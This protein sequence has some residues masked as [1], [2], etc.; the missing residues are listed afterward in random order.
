[1]QAV[2]TNTLNE[3]TNVKDELNSLFEKLNTADNMAKSAIE[4]N[5]VNFGA[6]AINFLIDKLIG[7]KGVQ[8]GVA[9]MSLIRIGEESIAPLKQL[10]VGNKN[11]EWV[12]NYIIQEIEGTF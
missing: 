5:I 9:A 1:M 6:S 3:I 11:F 8:R 4:N 2:L 7:S 12:A 10:A